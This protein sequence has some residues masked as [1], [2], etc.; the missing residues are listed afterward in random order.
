MKK[1]IIAL[2]A[3]SLFAMASVSTAES[4]TITTGWQAKRIQQEQNTNAQIAAKKKANQEKVSKHR[5]KVNARAAEKANKQRIQ[6]QKI[7]DRKIKVEAK[8]KQLREL[9]Q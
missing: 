7:K 2:L 5:A 3:F 8:K 4:K 1:K 6:E 9:F